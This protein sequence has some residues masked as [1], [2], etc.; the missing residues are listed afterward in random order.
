MDGPSPIPAASSNGGAAGGL[1]GLFFFGMAMLL[2][3]AGL[4]RAR[5]ISRLRRTAAAVAPQPFL[6]LLERPG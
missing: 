2:A 6:A 4:V 3:V 5:V 1:G